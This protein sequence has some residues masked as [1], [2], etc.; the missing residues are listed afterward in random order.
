MLLHSTV[1]CNITSD[2]VILPRWF[3]KETY[4]PSNLST[5]LK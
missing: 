5:L 3:G 2:P 1:T 4:V